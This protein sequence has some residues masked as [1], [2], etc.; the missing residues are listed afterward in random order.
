M[1]GKAQPQ[2]LQPG[3]LLVYWGKLP[4]QERM[5]P[6]HIAMA[7]LDGYI[8]HNT[9]ASGSKFA[10]VVKHKASLAAKAYV[11]EERTIEVYRLKGGGELATYAA[12][13]GETWVD[14]Q[15][16]NFGNDFKKAGQSTDS[17]PVLVGKYNEAHADTGK[18]H[19]DFKTLTP[20]MNPWLAGTEIG[21]FRGGKSP[22]SSGRLERG[23]NTPV[24]QWD[25]M[26]AFRAVKAY[27]RSCTLQGLSPRHGTSC[28][29]FVMYC[30]QAASLSSILG[31]E[32]PLRQEVIDLVA[33][34]PKQIKLYLNDGDLKK[35]L[36]EDLKDLQGPAFERL[37]A[38]LEKIS[39]DPA[40]TGFL[41][42]ALS[43]DAKTS[44]VAK[45][46]QKIQ[47]SDSGFVKEGS[48]TA[49]AVI[50]Q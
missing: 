29:Q 21:Q 3:D 10:G 46:F 40:K 31:P 50:V 49:D 32:S 44:S 2:A 28:D 11:K 14:Q 18:T 39:G 15:P 41:P 16:I 1:D 8:L 42:Q 22:Y 36:G 20:E 6:S 45:L 23:Q 9:I 27:V 13:F 30:Y 12:R 47:E 24:G 48:L 26:S 7:G 37:K 35:D 34:R 4:G 25:V 19:T 33:A 17:N 5:V 43:I 38:L